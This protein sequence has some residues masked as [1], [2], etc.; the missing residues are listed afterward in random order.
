MAP[1]TSLNSQ[2]MNRVA[3]QIDGKTLTCEAERSTGQIR[4]HAFDCKNNYGSGYHRRTLNIGR[5]KKQTRHR[6]DMCLKYETPFHLPDRQIKHTDRTLPI[7]IQDRTNV[8][9]ILSSDQLF[10]VSYEKPQKAHTRNISTLQ[11][12]DLSGVRNR[13]PY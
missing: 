2:Q 11:R 12:T 5:L 6:Q 10:I 4:S 9:D 13:Q 7:Y 1:V 8:L 3:I